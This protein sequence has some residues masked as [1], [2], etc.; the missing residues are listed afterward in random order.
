[1]SSEKSPPSH[2]N[3]LSHGRAST[4]ARS[5]FRFRNPP[6][7]S[8][9][10]RRF[11]R[12][13]AHSADIKIRRFARSPARS[14]GVAM[15]K[16]LKRLALAAGCVAS[17]GIILLF[18][19]ADF[20]Q[21]RGAGPLTVSPGRLTI[22][23]GS[24][25]AFATYRSPRPLSVGPDSRRRDQSYAAWWQTL[26]PTSTWQAFFLIFVRMPDVSSDGRHFTSDAVLY[27]Y[28]AP[29]VLVI[30][31]AS[32]LPLSVP[33]R[34]ALRRRLRRRRARGGLCPECGYDL[35]GGAARCPECGSEAGS[36]TNVLLSTHTVC[37]APVTR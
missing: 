33:V 4:C 10:A 6:V 34:I 36:V 31:A 8:L 27:Q 24:R 29:D 11:W 25:C 17:F 37:A 3:G 35:R 32:F 5:D 18:L 1:M 14:A 7:A 15:L 28:Q 12:T 21:R 13:A 22:G 30:A 9:W 23:V 20:S 16:S 26:E 19:L 2:E